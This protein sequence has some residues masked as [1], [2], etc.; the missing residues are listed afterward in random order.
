MKKGIEHDRMRFRTMTQNQL[1]TRLG[2]I[3]DQDKLER[4]VVLADEY[5]YRAL[6]DAAVLKMEKLKMT[7]YVAPTKRKGI[8][9]SP[10]IQKTTEKVIPKRAPVKSRFPSP[11]QPLKRYL[12]F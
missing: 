9:I 8:E 10:E 2:R 3:K 12:D 6:K 11:L 1:Y 4:F 5:G 7:F